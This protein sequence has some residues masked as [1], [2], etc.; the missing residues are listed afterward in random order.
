MNE[1]LSALEQDIGFLKSL[2]VEG[3][4]TPFVGGSILVGAGL[5]FG[6]A[7]VGQWAAATGLIP[8]LD[9]KSVV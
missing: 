7:S 3:R 4:P 9:R 8:A 1:R 2:A 6:T 5:I